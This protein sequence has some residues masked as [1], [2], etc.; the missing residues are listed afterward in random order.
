MKKNQQFSF[1]LFE[2]FYDPP[3]YRV[4]EHHSATKEQGPRTAN[5]T[6]LLIK[7]MK[8]GNVQFLLYEYI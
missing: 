1:P 2:K 8:Y 6:L 5:S 3:I 4:C 7:F